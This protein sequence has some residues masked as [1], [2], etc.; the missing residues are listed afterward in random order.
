MPYLP[1]AQR[2]AAGVEHRTL[3]DR[4]PRR[5]SILFSSDRICSVRSFSSPTVSNAVLMSRSRRT[6]RLGVR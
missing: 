6:P 4:P 1:E 3:A 2:Q 5:F